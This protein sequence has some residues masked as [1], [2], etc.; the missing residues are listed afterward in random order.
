M[1]PYF[2]IGF[3]LHIICLNGPCNVYL[4]REDVYI[5]VFNHVQIV[6]LVA[7]VCFSLKIFFFFA[8][9]E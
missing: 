6:N 7:S 3:Y 4:T 8:V 1:L 5:C 2:L 9:L